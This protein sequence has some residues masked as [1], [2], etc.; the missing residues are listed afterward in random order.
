MPANSLCYAAIFPA[1]RE[2]LSERGQDEKPDIAPSPL[3]FAVRRCYPAFRRCYFA[4]SA[5]VIDLS[6]T[7][8]S[9]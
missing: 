6:K 7:E 4:V 8:K 3:K 9:N 2:M 5:A 1:C